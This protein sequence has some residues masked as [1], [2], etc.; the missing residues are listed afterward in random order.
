MSQRQNGNK[1]QGVVRKRDPNYLTDL[2]AL[3][4]H[5]SR[6]SNDSVLQLPVGEHA[7]SSDDCRSSRARPG[8]FV[9][10]FNNIGVHGLRGFQI[11]VDK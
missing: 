7:I 10:P 3:L 9:Y 8:M 11:C 1:V 5:V 6:H 2:N 4:A